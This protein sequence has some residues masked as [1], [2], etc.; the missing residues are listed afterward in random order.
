MAVCNVKFSLHDLQQCPKMIIFGGGIKGI[1]HE[2]MPLYLE[3][4]VRDFFF[5]NVRLI[6]LS[7]P[8]KVTL[9]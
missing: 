2:E 7:I 6:F 3:G 5:P 1:F 8:F 4:V 9:L